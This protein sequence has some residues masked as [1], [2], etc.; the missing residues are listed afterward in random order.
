MRIARSVETELR[1]LMVRQGGELS[2]TKMWRG[3]REWSSGYI[4]NC[5][6]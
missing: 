6:A 5:E 2:G 1:G 4:D 3:N